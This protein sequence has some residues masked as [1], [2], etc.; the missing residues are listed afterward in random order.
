MP[1]L[2]YHTSRQPRL[3]FFLTSSPNST[4][5][6]LYTFIGTRKSHQKNPENQPLQMGASNSQG[7]YWLIQ[8]PHKSSSKPKLCNKMCS[9]MTKHGKKGV[10]SV[11]E[12]VSNQLFWFPRSK[13]PKNA[14]ISI[15]IL[16]Q[17]DLGQYGCKSCNIFFS[18]ELCGTSSQDKQPL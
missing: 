10:T 3:G 6:P 1:L 16:A 12:P 15:R 2:I 13:L 7:G 17:Q 18:F 8:P 11:C 4:I 9:L 14:I 5:G